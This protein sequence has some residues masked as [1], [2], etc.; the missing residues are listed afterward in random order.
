[1]PD[2]DFS[3]LNAQLLP[4]ALDL[5]GTWLPS[6]KRRGREYVC[7]GLQGGPGESLSVNLTT[8][9]WAEFN[10]LGAKG[11]DLISLYAAI[12]GI[13][14]GDAYRQLAGPAPANVKARHLPAAPPAPAVPNTLGPPPAGTQ[15][16][17]ALFDATAS[18]AYRDADGK[19]LFYVTRFD[20][21]GKKSF[22]PWSWDVAEARWVCK[23][24]PTPRPL[25]NLDKL[26]ADPKATVIICE[27]EKAADAACLLAPGSVGVTWPNGA[28]AVT[29]AAW[30][31]LKGRKVVIWP[32][33]DEPGRKASEALV[34]ILAPIVAD[35]SIIDTHDLTDG[36]DAADLTEPFGQWVK[37]RLMTPALPV[38][39]ALSVKPAGETKPA[40]AP[41]AAPAPR[42]PRVEVDATVTVTE[43][44]A[45]VSHSIAVLCEQY[46]LAVMGKSGLPICNIENALRVLDAV[47]G[48]TDLVWWDEF[49]ERLFTPPGREW[50]DRDTLSLLVRF[51]RDL[52]F[53]RLSDEM[54]YK[55]LLA[56][57]AHH[58]RNEPADWLNSLVW[59]GKPRVEGFLSRAFGAPDTDYI[60]AASRNWWRS[61]VARVL[62]PG[63][64]VDT[65]V[66]LEGPQGAGKSRALA[67]IGGKWFA[68]I[69]ESATSKDFYMC[70]SG[71]FLL[72]I[73]E[74]DAFSRA[75]VT[76]IKQVITSQSDRYRAP[77]GRAAE[78]HPRRCVFVGTTNETNYLRDATGGRRFWPVETGAAGPIDHAYIE[79]NREQLFAEAVMQVKAKERWYEMPIS[80][81]AMQE[82]RRSA[83]EWEELVAD[84]IARFPD[85][86]T[87]SQIWTDAFSQGLNKF[88][89]REQHRIANIL[90]SLKWKNL[91]SWDGHKTIRI[92]KPGKD[93][94]VIPATIP[95]VPLAPT[96]WQ[97]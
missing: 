11:G 86:V 10:G 51:Q 93:A 59:D 75:E 69:T 60:H 23:G 45:E 76:R 96:G 56:Y 18:W 29:S 28:G 66:I 8:G 84:F 36:F 64:K 20:E 22:R 43:D 91:P 49:H 63:C 58:V 37:L 83:D 80:T 95:G 13:G 79:A 41:K 14:Q 1:M 21:D 9:A 65:M 57:G 38:K 40:R 44:A 19:L 16:P 74:L 90:R 78:D 26:A 15:G 5:L 25:Y 50:T 32:D 39:P 24:W 85:G 27:G 54:L 12:Q 52:G 71:K 73:A 3:S 92:W 34:G 35:L 33:A 42:P 2:L 4:R 89:R 87:L 81:L 7:A 70:L 72:E 94:T 48:F 62:Y 67:I 82:S 17:A 88:D 53:Q 55:A 97:P 6:G 31:V 30:D 61:I 77:F 46:N 68:E 47:P